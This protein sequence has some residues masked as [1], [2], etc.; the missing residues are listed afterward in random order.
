MRILFGVQGTGNGH[1]SRSRE[2]VRKL[3]EDGHEVEVIVSGRKEDEL[4]EIGI[5]E[6]YRVMKGMTLVTYRGRLNYIETMF[7]LDFSRLMADVLT[8]DTSGLDLI[9]TDFE[10]V[11]SMAARIRGVPSLG[12][13]HQYAFRYAIPETRGNIFEKYTLLNFAP[14]RYNAGLH[15][16]HFNQPIFPPVIPPALYGGAHPEPVKGKVLVYLPFE[17]VDDVTAFVSPFAGYE[18]HIYGKVVE[19]RD[20]GH[21]HYRTY[22]R[23]GFLRDLM[24]CTGVVC[25]AGF[26]LPGEALHLGRK[27]LLRPLDGQIEQG[28]NALAMEQLGYG[29]A[30][31]S[32]DAEVLGTWL[33][34]PGRQPLRYARTVDYIA[35]WISSGRWD[36]LAHFSGAAWRDRG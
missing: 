35:E 33:E 17:E 23:E 34:K 28:S 19:D 5:F 2:L 29:M 10:P 25:N 12:F 20:E 31:H 15:W 14:A 26:E 32:L 36:D 21:L 16:H 24:E 11:T 8:L 30:M 27:L 13:G 9:I 4:R 3:K 6:P 18:F 22:S 1:I 7:Q